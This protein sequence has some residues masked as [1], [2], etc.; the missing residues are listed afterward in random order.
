WIDDGTFAEIIN[1]EI[2]S[3]KVDKVDFEA[4]KDIVAKN[5][6][7]VPITNYTDDSDNITQAI[8]TAINENVGNVLLFPP[9]TSYEI[10][11]TLHLPDNTF[12]LGY[13][14]Q[15]KMTTHGTM[16][17]VDNHV[18]IIGLEMIGFEKNLYLDDRA[19]SMKGAY[20]N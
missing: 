7:Y 16:F 3:W 8:Q 17:E 1:E 14:S 6:N 10:N 11:Q 20:N 2:F 4:F 13:G 5:H 18:A 15:M 9:N 19:I 12:L